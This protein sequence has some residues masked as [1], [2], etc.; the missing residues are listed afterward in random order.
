MV[1]PTGISEGIKGFT[2]NISSKIQSGEIYNYALTMFV[3]TTVFIFITLG[4]SEFAL[5][6]GNRAEIGMVL[7][8][9]IL[10]TLL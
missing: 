2:A 7:V 5:L 3:F 10:A 1:G 6:V 9:M 4:G 8:P